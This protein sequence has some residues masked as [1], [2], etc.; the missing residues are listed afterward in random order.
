MNEDI[1]M[2]EKNPDGNTSVKEKSKKKKADV[3]YRIYKKESH[4]DNRCILVG[5]DEIELAQ[6]NSGEIITVSNEQ[7]KI[8][9]CKVDDEGN[10]TSIPY[11][12]L[13]VE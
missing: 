13:G 3:L 9:G 12:W 7:I 11:R 8:I 2:D 1:K 4:K 6:F 5:V 10:I